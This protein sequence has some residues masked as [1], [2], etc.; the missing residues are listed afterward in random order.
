[1]VILATI[2]TIAS[3]L[4]F[5]SVD[6]YRQAAIRASL[7]S[8]VSGAMERIT[9]EL[10]SIV[11]TG[12]TVGPDITSA[13][14]NAITFNATTATAETI[15]YNSTTKLLTITSGAGAAQPLVQTCSDFTLTFFDKDNAST[16]VIA[17]IRR[18]GITITATDGALSESL[19]SKVYIRSMMSGS[20]AP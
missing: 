20:G 4:I 17:S 12:S 18:I 2:A 19:T 3:R 16:A 6:V 15:S 9:N 7:H 1:M 5:V 8:Q 10:R 14:S 11:A 13:A